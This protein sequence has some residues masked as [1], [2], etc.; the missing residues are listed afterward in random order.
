MEARRDRGVEEQHGRPFAD[1]PENRGVGDRCLM[2]FNAGPPMVPGGYNQN[3]QI[4]QAPGSFALTNEMIHNT[5]V[6]PTDGR[7]H[8]SIRLWAGDSRGHWEGDTLVVDTTN[9]YRDTSLQGSGPGM[10][11]IERFT[12][13][14]PDTINYE[15]TVDNPDT[16]TKPWTAIVPLVKVDDQVGRIFEYACQEGNYSLEGVLRGARLAEQTGGNAKK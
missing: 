7:P 12:R 10:H 5:R 8:G 4:V 3:V 2:G 13:V 11:L 15:F 16:W 9:F 1:S 14:S 6:I